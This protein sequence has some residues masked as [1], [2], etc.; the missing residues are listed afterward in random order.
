M[1]PDDLLAAY[2]HGLFPMDAEDQV[3]PIGFYYADPRAVLPIAD[4]RV[5][6]SVRRAMRR[7]GWEIHIDRDFAGV[8]RG[9]AAHRADGVWLTPRLARAYEDLHAAG[10]AHSVEVWSGGALAGGLFGVAL[11]GLYTSESMF[12][13][14]PD[15][16]NLALVAAAAHLHARGFMLWD[17]QMATPHTARFG[18]E[19]IAQ[20]EYRRRL[21]DALRLRRTF[22]P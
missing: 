19:R 16:G 22:A 21:R 6:G 3:G 14:V 17:I 13:R 2:A 5:P 12:H 15:A 7:P 1:R 18:A 11:G 9:C 10:W 8:V 4:L 20:S